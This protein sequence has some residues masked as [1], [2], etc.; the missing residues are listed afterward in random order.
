MKQEWASSI[1]GPTMLS[2]ALLPASGRNT[3]LEEAIVRVGWSLAKDMLV[4]NV[5]FLR[6]RLWRNQ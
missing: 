2:P 5:G 1:D 4:K 6:P 3:D